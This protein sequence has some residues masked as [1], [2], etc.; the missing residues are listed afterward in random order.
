LKLVWL[1]WKEVVAGGRDRKKEENRM[2]K[3][4]GE[5]EREKKKKAILANPAV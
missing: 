2:G 4:D 1:R 5:R 3:K